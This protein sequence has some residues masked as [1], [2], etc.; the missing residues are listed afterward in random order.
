M[1]R[2][3]E[4]GVRRWR[5]GH[6]WIFR[7]DLADVPDGIEPGALTAVEERKEASMQAVAQQLVPQ[8]NEV[9]AELTVALHCP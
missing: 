7:S 5:G 9:V 4:K 1:I 8:M 3:T 6:P 2:I